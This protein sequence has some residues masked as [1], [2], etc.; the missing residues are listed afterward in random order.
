MVEY[1][2]AGGWPWLER[3]QVWLAGRRYSGEIGDVCC[4]AATGGCMAVLQDAL[5]SGAAL[6]VRAIEAAARAGHLDMVK[7]LVDH[8]EQEGVAWDDTEGA[9]LLHGESVVRVR[10]GPRYMWCVCGWLAI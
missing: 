3:D 8:F 5:Q 6:T 7:H 2:A 4:L 1:A 10:R 9:W